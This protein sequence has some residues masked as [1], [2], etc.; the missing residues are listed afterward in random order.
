M[1]KSL[2]QIVQAVTGELKI[3]VPTVVISSS[4]TEIQQIY[5]LVIAACDELAQRHDW[6]QLMYTSSFTTVA[7]QNAY[8]LP[9]DFLRLIDNT[10]WNKTTTRPVYGPE[11]PEQWARLTRGVVTSGPTMMFRLQGNNFTFVPTPGE[12]DQIIFDYISAAYVI[13]AGTSAQKLT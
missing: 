8:P 12:A 3:N 7:G 4:D 6:E 2:L 5:A 11:S 9:S 10:L 1:R 13:D